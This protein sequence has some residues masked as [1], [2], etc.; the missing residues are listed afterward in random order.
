[1]GKLKVENKN[2]FIKYTLH[3]LIIC[4]KTLQ[5]IRENYSHEDKKKTWKKENQH[6]YIGNKIKFFTLQ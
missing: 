6:T 1:M 3:T 5:N 2:Q 4:N